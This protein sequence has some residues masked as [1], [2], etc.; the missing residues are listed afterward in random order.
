MEQWIRKCVVLQVA[1]AV[2]LDDK[3]KGLLKVPMLEKR[4]HKHVHHLY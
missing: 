4:A 2:Y 3:F 1:G